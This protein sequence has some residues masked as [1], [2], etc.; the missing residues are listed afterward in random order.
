MWH[1]TVLDRVNGGHAI[2]F[3][4]H[5]CITDGLGLVHVLNHLTDDN[6]L[7]G[8]TPS[9]VGHPHRAVAHNKVCSAVVR[10][11]SWLKIAAHWRAC[12]SCGPMRTASS[13]PR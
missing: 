1:M 5:H 12:P 7:H 2:V 8:K 3:R 11:L 9:P 13:R 10:G 4:V 6:G